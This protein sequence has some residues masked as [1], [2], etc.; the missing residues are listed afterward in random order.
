LE[1]RFLAIAIQTDKN[2]DNNTTPQLGQTYT[3]GTQQRT[4]HHKLTMSTP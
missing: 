2:V 1:T 3:H 4:L